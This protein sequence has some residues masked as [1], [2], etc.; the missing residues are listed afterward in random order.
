M[1]L[2][3]HEVKKQAMWQKKSGKST[4]HRMQQRN[5][6]LKKQSHMEQQITTLGKHK[7]SESTFK[8][9]GNKPMN[10]QPKLEV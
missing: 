1:Y 4:H 2:N 5:C 3:R 9:L 8:I 6:E 10:H 7:S